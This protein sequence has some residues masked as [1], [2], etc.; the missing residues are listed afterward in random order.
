MCGRF[1]LKTPAHRWV[2]ELFPE[3]EVLG[4][5]ETRPR[6]NVAPTQHI[7]TITP[8]EEVGR[9]R[10]V[11][12]RWGLIP[13]WS[14]DM[15]IGARMINARSET[16]HEKPSFKKSFAARRCIIPTDGYYEWLREGNSKRPFWIHRPDEGVIAM[17]GLWEANRRI[18]PE[19]PLLSATIITTSANKVT[20]AVHDRMPVVLLGNELKRWLD[21]N[22]E[23]VVLLRTML[24]PAPDDLLITTEVTSHVNNARNDDPRCLDQV[25]S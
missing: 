12:M 19:E 25:A 22:L 2:Q 14:E 23:D 24:K 17:A 18:Q 7:L 15:S 8:A 11:P 13:S 10:V 9:L 3:Y 6:Y 21:P 4:V 1:T 20:S 16:V 5:T